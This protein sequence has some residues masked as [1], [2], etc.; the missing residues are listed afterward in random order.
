MTN[1]TESIE[2]SAGHHLEQSVADFVCLAEVRALR[3]SIEQRLEVFPGWLDEQ[4][5]AGDFVEAAW[6][7]SLHFIAP[8][9]AAVCTALNRIVTHD[10]PS[11]TSCK[12]AGQPYLV[13]VCGRARQRP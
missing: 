1:K 13:S 3:E 2:M 10:A 7:Y 6:H 4:A 11:G 8:M 12:G 5:E 9:V